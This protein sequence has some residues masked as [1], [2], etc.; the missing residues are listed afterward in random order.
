MPQAFQSTL[1]QIEKSPAFANFKK[2]NP[3]AKLCAGFFVI[4]LESGELQ[5][6]TNETT[7]KQL[8]YCLPD[9]K[10][11]TFIINQATNEITIKEAETLEQTKE[12]KEDESK[13]LQPLNKQN[14]KIDL[15]DILLILKSEFQVRGISKK[16]N[17]IIAILQ[18]YENREIWNLTCM[19]AG[20]EMIQI[21]INSESGDILKFEKKN[22]FEFIKK[23]K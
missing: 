16:L 19:L 21:H 13:K 23:V 18:N 4:N 22:M 9:N 14:I 17:K 20:F 7:Q 11:F 1:E 15:D 5:G 6:A 8:D 12:Q 3:D 10:I 2:Q